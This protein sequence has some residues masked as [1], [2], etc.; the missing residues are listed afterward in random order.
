[1]KPTRRLG[2]AALAGAGAALA[3]RPLTVDD[4]DPVEVGQFE[5]EAGAAWSRGSGCKH[6]DL[7][8]GLTYGGFRNAEIGAGFGVQ[9]EIRTER[10]EHGGE[11]RKR[12]RGLGDLTMG[13]KWRFLESCP[14]GARHALVPSV[15]VPTADEDR[16]L[17]SGRAD[18]DLTWIASR[19]IGGKAG[20]HLN[21]GYSRIGGPDDDAFHY[22]AAL[23]YQIT[24]TVQ[25][26]GEVF[27]ETTRAGDS[28]TAA[29][30]S[31]GVRWNPA[32]SLMLDAAGGTKVT[33]EAPDFTATVGL[34]WTFGFIGGGGR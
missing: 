26:A 15:K 18:Y 21:L 10:Q 5:L 7:P 25:W 33:G 11:T 14:L 22:G 20:A 32:A 2:A 31:S 23:D 34:T 12:N 9:S 16:E 19:A 17:G 28:D 3:G 4:A 29:Q 13:A 27:A 24:E 6:G 8:F 1:M 30:V